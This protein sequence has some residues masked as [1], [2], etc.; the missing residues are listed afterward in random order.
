MDAGDSVRRRVSIDGTD[1]CLRHRALVRFE[2]FCF[3]DLAG[4]AELRYLSRT[5]WIIVIA[6]RCRSKVS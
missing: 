3:R 5:G 6:S 2:V 1:Y 4:D